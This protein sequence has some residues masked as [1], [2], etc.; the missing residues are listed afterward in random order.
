M[1]NSLRLALLC[2]LISLPS[3]ARA[4][5]ALRLEG[6]CEKL[7]IGPQDLS[8]S[9]SNVLTN[10]VSRNRTSFDFTTADGQTVS[11]SGNGAQQEAT[12]ETDP[13]QP[14][15]VVTIGKDA[16]PT[17]AIGA[18]RFSTLEP[19][20]TAITCEANAADGRAFAGTFVTA[21]KAAAGAPGAAPAR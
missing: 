17:L 9:C 12:E 13:L 2:A 5:A 6:T 15:N 19:G 7:M 10:A 8:Q 16:G 21:A 4:Q 1:T 11:F 20:R 14:I 18:C 3:A